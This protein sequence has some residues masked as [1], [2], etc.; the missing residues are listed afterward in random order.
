MRFE[1]QLRLIKKDDTLT[2]KKYRSQEPSVKKE[3]VNE[4]NGNPNWAGDD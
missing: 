4:Y 1:L 2:S 3:N